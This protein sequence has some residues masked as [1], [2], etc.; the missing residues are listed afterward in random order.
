MESWFANVDFY[1]I[2]IS[3]FKWLITLPPLFL[4]PASKNSEEVIEP[5]INTKR[6]GNIKIN[7]NYAI[8]SAKFCVFSCDLWI[9]EARINWARKKLVGVEGIKN[10]NA[11]QHFITKINRRVSSNLNFIKALTCTSS[12][13][14]KENTLRRKVLTSVRSTN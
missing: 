11:P 3:D 8:N 4:Y 14:K 12:L 5:F 10:F 2:I 7:T 6:T 13:C 9:E 1:N